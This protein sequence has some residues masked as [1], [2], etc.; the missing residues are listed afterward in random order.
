MNRVVFSSQSVEWAT[1]AA[2]YDQL[3]A[4]FHFDLDP[5]P[6]GRGG[7]DG[8]SPLFAWTGRHVYCNPPYG[9]QI[10]KWLERAMEAE[11]AAF[12]LPARVDTRWFHELCLPYA[13]E[14]RF[15]KG[16]LKF[17]GARHNASF[18][19]MVVIFKGGVR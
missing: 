12:L 9:R 3:H 2:V 19:S 6:L 13:S 18:P 14:I 5:C 17:G 7:G 4:E 15:I 16:R 11:V 10:R 8:L 1:P